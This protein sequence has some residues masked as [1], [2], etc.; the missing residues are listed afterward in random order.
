[1]D[2]AFEKRWRDLLKDLSA[3]FETPLDMN[4]VVFLVGVQELGQEARAFKKDEKMDLMHIGTC[5][6]LKP[7]G[8][9]RDRGRDADGWPHFDRVKELPP[10]SP[11]E[12]EHMMKAAIL[13]YFGR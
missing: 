9:Y 11:K 5:V 4:S 8:Y 10:L 7:L 2:L 1:M 13:E 6:L 3:R 12:Q